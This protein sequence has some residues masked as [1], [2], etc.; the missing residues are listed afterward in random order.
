MHQE[1]PR[2]IAV[3]DRLAAGDRFWPSLGAAVRAGVT[4]IQLREKDLPADDLLA[5]GRRI[6]ALG[7]VRLVVNDRVDVALALGAWGVQLG[8]RSLPPDEVRRIAPNLVIG[9]SVHETERIR[10][11]DGLCDYF[12]FGNLFETSCKPGVAAKSIDALRAAC[13]ATSKPVYAIGGIDASNVRQALDAGAYGVAV[14]S[15]AYLS[16]TGLPDLAGI[17]AL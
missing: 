1:L 3:T 10:R 13:A 17:F 7:P 15:L 2:I 14:R 5:M 9:R 8:E 6:M 11:H 4:T 16:G 12:L